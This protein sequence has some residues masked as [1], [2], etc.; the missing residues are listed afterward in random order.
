MQAAEISPY[1]TV[2]WEFTFA[3]LYIVF[4]CSNPVTYSVKYQQTSYDNSITMK[5]MSWYFQV[6][7]FYKS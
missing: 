2:L 1:N 7:G 6:N 4:T 5:L 3:K